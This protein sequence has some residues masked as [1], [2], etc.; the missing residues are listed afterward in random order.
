MQ[1]TQPSDPDSLSFL[2]GAP[3]AGAALET[4]DASAAL[5][6]LGAPHPV[7]HTLCVSLD[8]VA[9]LAA[10]IL[11]APL[12]VVS[13]VGAA[14]PLATGG[15]GDM[16]AWTARRGAT[17]DETLCRLVLDGEPVLLRDAREH[18]LVLAEPGLWM[19]E[20]GYAG[21]P[22]RG[23]DGTARGVLCV[24]DR[25]PREWTHEHAEVL[26][27]LA[28]VVAVGLN[29]ANGNGNGAARRGVSLRMLEKAV[30]TMQL[31]VTITDT[32]G[33][34]VYT[35]PAEA[36]M[37]GYD[38]G[39]LRGRHA[40]IF[41]PAEHAKPIGLEAMG[42]VK[43]WSRETTNVRRDGTV[44]P[45]MLR[46]DV[47]TDAGGEPVGLVTCCE[48]IT[49]RKEMERQL[50]HQAFYDTLTGL[51]NRGLFL[52]RLE[53]SID[54]ARRGDARFAVLAVGL[55]GFKL[56]NDSLGH[57]A[58][59]ELLTAVGERLKGRVRAETMVAHLAGDEFAVL[60]DDIDGLTDATRVAG[61][62]QEALG[63]AFTVDLREIFTSATV[64]IA[65]S[66]TGYDRPDEV[67]RDAVIAMYR[68]KAAGKGLYEVFDTAMHAQAM[69]RLRMETDLRRAVERGELR[70]HYQPIVTLRTGRIAGFEALV[71][72]Q[73]P[74]RGLVQPDD[75]IPLAE[76]TG[77]IVPIGMWVL[78]EAC[79]QLRRLRQVKGGPEL[80]VAVNLS[81][82]QFAQPDLVERIAAELERTG[83]DP[84]RLKLEITESTIMQHSEGVTET[85]HRLKALGIQLYIDDFGTGYSS[86]SYLHRLPLDALKID[87]SFISG[88]DGTQNLP[89]V[90][91][92]V[93]LA[94]ALDVV[95]VTEGIESAEL[96]GELRSLR[97]E[98]GQ[99]F[100]FSR[101]LDGESTLALCAS[102][103]R[104]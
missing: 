6:H 34:I 57:T 37:H 52:N 35:N 69:E 30:E 32:S 39:E 67:L 86:L 31:G 41:A 75:F 90:R 13:A 24:L 28:A 78:G 102:D 29:G 49:Q 42:A 15:D 54:R 66:D 81:A 12:A 50:L 1:Y 91:A 71:R 79:R 76:D 80:T 62:V 48:D 100:F 20:A 99:G 72:W 60:L 18:A 104:W 40:R 73:H 11:R 96:L 23:H 25:R 65:L 53:R 16:D 101:P 2:N 33:C 9:A 17:L 93:A 3:L 59:D 68:S 7:D 27:G 94:H 5:F 43:S 103:P 85:L 83:V 36:R 88:R 51:P 14:R 22:I 63:Q 44:F 26:A 4:L 97:C 87:R 98:Y 70:V 8:S 38:A 84:A 10:R 92:I 55:D 47:V 95:V 74:E 21:V 46:S 58:G 89:L 61:R 45:V 56:V 82:R 77:L 19:G 64:G